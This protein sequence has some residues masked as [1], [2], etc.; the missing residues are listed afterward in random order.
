LSGSD[1]ARIPSSE[2]PTKP[3]RPAD[4]IS[5]ANDRARVLM[6]TSTVGEI[7]TSLVASRLG[8]VMESAGKRSMILDT[9]IRKAEDTTDQPLAIAAPGNGANLGEA[10]DRDELAN[11]WA[12]PKGE[13]CTDVAT[14]PKCGSPES[15]HGVD[16]SSDASSVSVG[17]GRA[18]PA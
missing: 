5:D 11:D 6:L 17:G 18:E 13:A 2:P 3:P 7:D 8:C 10:E 15:E 12:D 4:G 9:R 16:E 1:R 14:V